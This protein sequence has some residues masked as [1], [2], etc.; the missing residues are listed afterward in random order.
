MP[1][2]KVAFITVRKAIKT[3]DRTC[4]SEAM[5]IMP[6]TIMIKQIPLSARVSFPMRALETPCQASAKA[7][8]SAVL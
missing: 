5:I 8:T 2:P 7:R 6:L 4:C 1:A 3:P